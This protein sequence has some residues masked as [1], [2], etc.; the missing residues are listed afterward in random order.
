[1]VSYFGWL[2]YCDFKNLLKIEKCLQ[3][4]KLNLQLDPKYLSR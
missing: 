1:M 3:Q 4:Q 2:K